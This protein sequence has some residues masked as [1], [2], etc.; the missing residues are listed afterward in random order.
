MWD[1][2]HVG[3]AR[4]C[5]VEPLRFGGYLLLSHSAWPILINTEKGTHDPLW[6]SVTVWLRVGSGK[7]CGGSTEGT[8]EVGLKGGLEG[9][10]WIRCEN[11]HFPTKAKSTHEGLEA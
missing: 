10:R 5:C 2:K 3:D 9:L 4:F 11:K 1:V 6:C 8:F 7:F